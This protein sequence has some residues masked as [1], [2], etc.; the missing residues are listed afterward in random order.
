[1]KISMKPVP[2]P[3]LVGGTLILAALG[4]PGPEQVLAR[5]GAELQGRLDRGEVQVDPAELL[6]LMHDRTVR[7]R[8]V[9]IRPRRPGTGSISLTPNI[10]TRRP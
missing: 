4:D 7:L 8:I 6:D 3:V 10:S 1:M 2:A 5:R 9:D